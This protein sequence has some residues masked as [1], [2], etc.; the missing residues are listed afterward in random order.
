[1]TPAERGVLTFV[2]KGLSNKVIA[3]AIGIS[4]ATV[5]AHLHAVYTKLGVKNRTGAVYA[6]RRSAGE[7]GVSA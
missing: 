5:K 3:Q 4:P 6:L 7:G 1:M 2:E